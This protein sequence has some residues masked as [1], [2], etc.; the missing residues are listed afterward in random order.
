MHDRADGDVAFD[1]LAVDGGGVTGG[2]VVGGVVPGSEIGTMRVVDAGSAEVEI[3]ADATEDAVTAPH[4]PKMRTVQSDLGSRRRR[5]S[6]VRLLAF[7]GFSPWRVDGSFEDV[8][9][10]GSG[11]TLLQNAVNCMVQFAGTKSAEADWLGEG[12]IW[13][14][15]PTSG[16]WNCVQPQVTPISSTSGGRAAELAVRGQ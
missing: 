6:V 14:S 13:M 8:G 1:D 12:F 7:D 2:R 9:L 15:R 16:T 5:H 10:G 11:L 3:T 4:S